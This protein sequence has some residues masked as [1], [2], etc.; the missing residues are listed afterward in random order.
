M[1]WYIAMVSAFFFSGRANSIVA[2]PL[3][4]LNRTYGVD[5]IPDQE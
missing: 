2:T 5:V 4:I 3:A 1:A